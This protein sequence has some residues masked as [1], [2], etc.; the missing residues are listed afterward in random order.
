MA[1]HPRA[2]AVLA[3]FDF[4]ANAELALAW[5]AILFALIGETYVT[6]LF[7]CK[8]GGEKEGFGGGW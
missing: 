2:L 5:L 1:G 4:L 6:T 3:S 7:R 8:L